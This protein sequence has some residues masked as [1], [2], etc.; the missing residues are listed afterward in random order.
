[1]FQAIRYRVV[2]FLIDR[3]LKRSVR[4]RAALNL[5]DCRHV[6]ILFALENEEIYRKVNS[7]IFNLTEQH[8][9]VSAIGLLPGNTVP[10]YYLAKL[11]IDLIGKKDINLLGVPVTD[12]VK[13][14]TGQSFDILIDLSLGDHLALDYIAAVS[15]ARFKTGPFRDDMVKVFD[16]MIKHPENGSFNDFYHTMFEYLTSINTSRS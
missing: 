2:H 14:F 1:M 5:N 10:N 3:A 13:R 16:F 6:G 11:K 7:L 15:L 8:K 12:A 9:T 4:K